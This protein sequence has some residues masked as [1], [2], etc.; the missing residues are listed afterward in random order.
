MPPEWYTRYGARLENFCL[1]KDQA[2]RHTL[3][4]LIGANVIALLQ[5]LYAPV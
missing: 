2:K 3:A 5:A 1:P 4:E